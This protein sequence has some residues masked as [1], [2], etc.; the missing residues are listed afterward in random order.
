MEFSEFSKL[1]VIDSHVHFRA[2]P[3]ATEEEVKKLIPWVTGL[4]LV[5]ILAGS[6]ASAVSDASPID[7][8]IPDNETISNQAEA[9]NSSRSATITITMIGVID[10]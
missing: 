5:M 10:E 8:D 6:S 3:K 1:P 9:G 4:V 7:S 2:P